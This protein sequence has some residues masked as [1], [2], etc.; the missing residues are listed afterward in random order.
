MA[1]LLL[2]VAIAAVASFLSM[3]ADLVLKPHPA[4]EPGG[5]LVTIGQSRGVGLSGLPASLVGRIADEAA[6][7]DGVGGIMNMSLPFEVRPGGEP[8][9]LSFFTRGY[10][11]TLDPRLHLGRG[12]LSQEHD[13]DAEF[14]A[15]LSHDF[16]LDHFGGDEDIIDTTFALARVNLNPALQGE[17]DEE[18]PTEFRI[19]GVLPPDAASTG[20]SQA[21]VFV[22]VERAAPIFLG[23]PLQ[24]NFYSARAYARLAPGMSLEGVVSELNS[25]YVETGESLGLEAGARI[26]V[27]SGIVV[28]MSAQ[29][30][31]RRQLQLFLAGSVLLAVVAAA[32]VSLFLLARAPGRRRELG[33][34]M[35][36]GAPGRRL[37]RQLATEASLLVAAAA[38]LGVLIS[39]WSSALLSDLPF[40]QRAEWQQLTVF[41][42]RVL[43]VIG[44]FTLVLAVAVSLSPMLGIR[45]L[46]IAASARQV[47]ARATPLQHIVYTTQ[48]AIAG[49]I[50]GAAIAFA[51]VLGSLTYG[52]FGYET[53]DR[54]VARFSPVV[55]PGP[56]TIG[57][58]NL[59]TARWREAIESVPGIEA[60]TFSNIVPGAATMRLVFQL[61]DPDDPTRSV[62][63]QSVT[64][65]ERFI[66]LLGLELVRGQNL[67]AGQ[68]DGLLINESF[69]RSY[70]GHTDV[71]GEQVPLGRRG[72]ETTQVVGVLR[73][74]SFDHPSAEVPPF[75]FASMI[76]A[77]ASLAVIDTTMPIQDLRQSLQSLIDAGAIEFELEELRR[78]RDL[79]LDLIAPDRARAVLTLSM[80]FLVVL[81]AALGFYGTQQFLV[82]AGRREY[83][84]RGSLG[85]GPKAL[86]RLVLRR[87]F[88]LSLPGLVLGALLAFI[89]VAWLR[90]S[91]VP[92]EISPALVTGAVVSG[93][94]CLLVAAGLGP[95]DQARRTQPAPLLRED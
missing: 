72:A 56:P 10:F 38:V 30:E 17:A 92:R 57:S 88:L 2:A 75:L 48:L 4:F 58:A 66:D 40:L 49:A 35:A 46:G 43:G 50:A 84:I 62:Q 31:V 7:L 94:L 71:V 70:W 53:Q 65:D 33:I 83:A 55:P 59:D 67:A 24:G 28:S 32:N 86:G 87:G 89:V 11:D 76:S 73:D 16:W 6:T 29:R 20:F 77:S 13:E 3:Y 44:A 47:A 90:D 25:R 34:R 26:E 41:D 37:A 12:F 14:V 74:L 8:V 60:A 82:S 1:V 54:Y 18:D 23:A 15:V 69:A 61:E 95:A 45:R 19:V 27:V 22:P 85:A 52:D 51:W 81:L 68:L 80:A 5:R 63:A 79:R 21:G 42:W 78:L 64:T 93:L 39:V 36:V 9:N 91:Y